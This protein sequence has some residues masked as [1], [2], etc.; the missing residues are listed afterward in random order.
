[1]S[2][3]WD[4]ALAAYARDGAAEACLILQDAHGQNVP[5]LLWAVWS[6]RERRAPDDAAVGQAA[7]LARRWEAAAT[8]PLRSVR[9]ELKQDMDG[10][11]AAERIAF[12]DHVKAVELEAERLLM[13]NLELLAS[14]EPAARDEAE[15]LS[16]VASAYGAALEPGRFGPLLAAL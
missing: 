9:R 7:A 4:W 13:R 16:A 11:P 15:L 6:S 2:A 8:A 14:A 3:L 10:V 1:M 12:R 5:L